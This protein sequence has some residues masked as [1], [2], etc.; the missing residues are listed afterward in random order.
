MSDT[1]FYMNPPKEHRFTPGQS[2]NPN[3]RPKGAVSIMKRF[4][5]FLDEPDKD[6][7]TLSR[8][9]KL[10]LKYV[11]IAEKAGEECEY[12][13]GQRAFN[14]V[15]D[16][17]YGKPVQ[18]AEID[19]GKGNKQFASEAEHREFNRQRLIALQRK[20]IERTDEVVNE[21]E[22]ILDSEIKESKSEW[23]FTDRTVRYVDICHKL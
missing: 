6:D 2:G 23:F 9:E 13:D 15:L 7:P 20:A 16:R 18:R 19:D 17:A 4:Q 10:F 3:G 11:G 12:A 8:G 1:S 22:N 21:A 14:A 5:R